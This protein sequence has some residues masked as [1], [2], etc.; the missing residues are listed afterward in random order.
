MIKRL[1]ILITF[2]VFLFPLPVLAQDWVYRVSDGQFQVG[3]QGTPEKIHTEPENY[4]IVTLDHTPNPRLE[5]WDGASGARS[6]TQDE[7][8]SYDQVTAEKDALIFIQDREIRAL[9]WE[10]IEAVAPPANA[11]K[12]NNTIN[13]LKETWRDQPWSE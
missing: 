5:V 1:I 4:G 8:D 2:L 12:F 11:T 7:I 10:I 9:I 3:D 13:N 6:A